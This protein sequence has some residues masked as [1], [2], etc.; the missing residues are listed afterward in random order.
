MPATNRCVRHKGKP[1]KSSS[2]LKVL[3]IVS[4]GLSRAEWYKWI[5]EN[6]A[7]SATMPNPGDHEPDPPTPEQAAAL[8][9]LAFAD[10]EFRLFWTAFTTGGR[11]SELP[12]LRPGPLRRRA[13][14][15]HRAQRR[16]PQARQP[17]RR[18]PPRLPLDPY[19]L[20]LGHCLTV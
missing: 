13:R 2:R 19:P 5:D 9:N 12:G 17:A 20:R 6:L 15:R 3:S 11:R 16:P 10:E 7:E 18:H 8:L 1:L 4:A 14:Q